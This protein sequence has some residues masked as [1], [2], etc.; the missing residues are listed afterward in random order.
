MSLVKRHYN[1]AQIIQQL[2]RVIKT[3]TCTSLLNMLENITRICKIQHLGTCLLGPGVK[4]RCVEW[5]LEK[6]LLPRKLSDEFGG[7]H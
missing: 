5:V 7:Y 2:A 4:H 3:H 1:I 6:A